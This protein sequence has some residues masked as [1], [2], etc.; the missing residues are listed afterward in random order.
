M[1]YHQVVRHE[2]A[3]LW[4]TFIHGA[5]STSSIWKGQLSDFGQHF[6]L[7]LVDLRGHGNSADLGKED[8]DFDTVVND[9]IEVVEALKIEKSVFVGLSMG[10]II[11]KKI[12]KKKP[13]LVSHIVL[14][15]AVFTYNFVLSIIYQVGGLLNKILPFSLLSL[16]MPSVIL[17]LPSHKKGRTFLKGIIKKWGQENYQKWYDLIPQITKEIAELA[18]VGAAIPTLL[19]MGAEDFL[20]LPNAQ[21]IVKQQPAYILKI[22]PA[23]SHLVNYQRPKEFNKLVLEF[24]LER[25]LQM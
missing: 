10:T 13:Q 15:G 9:V 17:P 16:L 12:A 18:Y 21:T 24:L 25:N 2:S 11:V 7:L 22:I 23:C 14:G 4:V 8:Y 3:K 5:A 19:V 20:F 6:N 1:I